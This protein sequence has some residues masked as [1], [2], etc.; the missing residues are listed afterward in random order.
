MRFLEAFL[1]AFEMDFLDFVFSLLEV[2]PLLLFLLGDFPRLL[3][4]AFDFN[5]FSSC[6]S[7]SGFSCFGFPLSL[8]ILFCLCLNC[9][10]CS[11]SSDSSFLS[12]FLPLCFFLPLTRFISPFPQ[13]FS[14]TVFRYT[15]PSFA[16]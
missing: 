6:F 10:T 15:I 1:S 11:K 5:S 13:L 16:N 12:D 4:E 7:E 9:S 14:P 2:L 3:L 8:L